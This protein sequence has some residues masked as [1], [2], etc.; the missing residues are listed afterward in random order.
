M[1]LG[2]RVNAKNA[3]EGVVRAE[4]VPSAAMAQLDAKE[5]TYHPR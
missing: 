3:R 1:V 4:Q 2:G 5:L